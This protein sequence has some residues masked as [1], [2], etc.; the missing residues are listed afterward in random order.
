MK[1]GRGRM[2]RRT[3]AK[4]AVLAVFWAGFDMPE[5]DVTVRTIFSG[6]AV[7]RPHINENCAAREVRRRLDR[8]PTFAPCREKVQPSRRG[9][10]LIGLDFRDWS[11]DT[12]RAWQSAAERSRAPRQLKKTAQRR[13]RALFFSLASRCAA[14]RPTA[15]QKLP[16][17]LDH[18]RTDGWLAF[19]SPSISIRSVGLGA[20][21]SRSA[22]TFVPTQHARLHFHPPSTSRPAKT[23]TRPRSHARA[24]T[25]SP[26]SLRARAASSFLSSRFRL[27]YTLVPAAMDSAKI[28]ALGLAAGLAIHVFVR[29][30]ARKGAKHAQQ[31]AAPPSPSIASKPAKKN[32]NKKNKNKDSPT[33]PSTEAV[34]APAAPAPAPAPEPVAK[35]VESAPAATT[36]KK[37][38]KNKKQ[39]PQPNAQATTPAESY[40]EVAAA[41]DAAPAKEAVSN[42]AISN[43]AVRAR[44]DAAQAALVAS[45]GDMR[46]ADVDELPAGYSSVARIPAS[47]PAATHRISRKDQDDGWS[48][49]GGTFPSSSR[50]SASSAK[51]NGTATHTSFASTNPFAALP[52]DAPTASVK[53]LPPSPRLPRV[54]DGLLPLRARSRRVPTAPRAWWAQAARP[55]NSARTPTR[56]RPRRRPRRMRSGCRPSGSPTTADSRRLRL[57]SSETPLVDP[58]RTR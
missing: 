16:L 3:E 37:N 25:P 7:V 21:S 47:E 23:H 27:S 35:P 11:C 4:D 19:L 58:L 36:S 29:N 20:K 2:Q 17:F 55:R 12:L 40:A 5:E 18:P 13:S 53:R 26:A 39:H 1:V 34:A 51:P 41:D 45:L 32:K 6:C 33:P 49:V 56:L 30:G 14:L 9:R 52:D 10:R 28:F 15:V 22:S 48:S 50:A 24:H 38:K 44:S 54:V 42:D 43:D 57:H 8:C 31:A 46:D